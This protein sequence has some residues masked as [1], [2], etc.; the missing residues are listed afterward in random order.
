MLYK[1]Y[2]FVVKA[3]AHKKD[4]VATFMPKPVYGDNGSGMHVHISI[5][6]GD[7]NLF[8][9]PDDEYA[10]LSQFARYFIGG[11]IEHGR[12]L[13]AIVSPRFLGVNELP[14]SFDEALDELGYDNEWLKLVF[15]KRP[16]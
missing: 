1:Q 8:Y 7:E 4:V 9:D 5:W 16:Y 11:L 14:R 13:S 6:R 2:E 10:Y 3:L 12:A 15:S